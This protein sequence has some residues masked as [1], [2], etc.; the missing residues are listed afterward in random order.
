MYKSCCLSSFDVQPV[1]VCVIEIPYSGKF[2]W[3]QTFVKMP[4]EAPDEI[5]AGFI[6]V[7]KPCIVQY[8]LGC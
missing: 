3:V 2:L 8:Q 4:P 7:T 5:F 6:F 1:S